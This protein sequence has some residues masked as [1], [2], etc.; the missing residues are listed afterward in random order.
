[1]DAAATRSGNCS[2]KSTS[3]STAETVACAVFGAAGAAIGIPAAAQRFGV[4]NEVAAFGA[5]ATAF[6]AARVSSGVARAL[7]DSA[8]IAG[9][10]LGVAEIVRRMQQAALVADKAQ[11]REPACSTDQRKPPAPEAASEKAPR[12]PSSPPV[13]TETRN[14]GAAE[15][16]PLVRKSDASLPSFRES[17]STPCGRE[18]NSTSSAGLDGKGSATSLSAAAAKLSPASERISQAQ[19]DHYLAIYAR[20]DDVERSELS[21]LLATLPAYELKR[22]EAQLLGKTP[23]E[24]VDFLRGSVFVLPRRFAS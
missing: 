9:V 15:C 8:A 5:A 16:L 22:V 3:L 18:S 17:A 2:Q 10:C 7:F 21:T 24:A 6:V 20:L 12:I 23:V 4:R 1:M 13:A 14:D 19:I 11:S